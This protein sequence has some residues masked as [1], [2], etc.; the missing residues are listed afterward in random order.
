MARRR[1]I[2]ARLPLAPVFALLFGTAFA[3][4][5]AA[6]PDWRFEQAVGW[7]GLGS[8]LSVA[9]PP[10]G[11]KARL[12]AVMLVFALIA[13]LVWFA[14]TAVERLLAPQAPQEDDDE[15]LDLAAFA[16][17]LPPLDKPR[18]PI[19]ADKELGAPFMSDEAL[20]TVP[21][22]LPEVTAAPDT[23][24]PPVV[25]H[26]EAVEPVIAG[27][28]QLSGEV[29]DLEMPLDV[30]E[31]DLPLPPQDFA[32]IPGESSIDTLIRRLEAGMARR[33]GPRPPSPP[34]SGSPMPNPVSEMRELLELN[35]EPDLSRDIGSDRALDTLQRLAAR[36][37]VV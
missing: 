29:V 30:A 11:L 35:R 9:R 22:V 32:A 12:L 31:F 20:R 21:V 25:D 6:M 3:I 33:A 23:P 18:R 34:T 19:F 2:I 36:R 14:V 16:E 7:T 17:T 10:L 13:I 1:N 5:V 37:T 26:V 4:V 15:F 28:E 24:T 27:S 8:M